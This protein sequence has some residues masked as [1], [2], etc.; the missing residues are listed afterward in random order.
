MRPELSNDFRTGLME[1]FNNITRCW[2]PK[3]I[4]LHVDYIKYYCYKY[5]VIRFYVEKLSP[6]K[7]KLQN[8]QHR[9]NN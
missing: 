6:F 7:V 8:C 4:S 9:M 5:F 2:T 3:V 1:K